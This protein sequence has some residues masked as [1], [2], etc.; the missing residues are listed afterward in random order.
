MVI[1][2]FNLKTQKSNTGYI[3]KININSYLLQTKHYNIIL[4]TK[5]KLNYYDQIS[6]NI[7]DLKTV[8]AFKNT[9]GFNQENYFISNNIKYQLNSNNLNITKSNSFKAQ[10]KTYIDSLNDQH[11][12]ILNYFIFGIRDYENIR[13]FVLESGLNYIGLGYLIEKIFRIFI[14]KKYSKLIK[15][16]ILSLYF[17][18]NSSFSLLRIIIYESLRYF[19]SNKFQAFGYSGLIILLLWPYKVYSVAFI[20]PFL[21]KVFELFNILNIKHKTCLILLSSFFFSK[22]NF[23][24]IFFFKFL[25]YIH[26]LMILCSFIFLY[27]S[28]VLIFLFGL[29]QNLLNIFSNKMFIVLGKINIIGIL[30]FMLFKTLFKKIKYI[31]NTVIITLVLLFNLSHIHSQVAIINVGDGDSILIKDRFNTANILIDTASPQ[32]YSKVRDF[33]YAKGVKTIDYLVITHYDLDHYGNLERLKKDFKVKN[34]MDKHTD[35]K[36][37]NMHFLSLNKPHKSKNDSSIVYL[38]NLN[39]LN[40]LFTGDITKIV[41]KSIINQYPLLK[42]DILKAG[43]H[44]SNTSSDANFIKEIDPMLALISCGN[45]YGFPKKETIKTFADNLIPYYVTK[46]RGDLQLYITAFGN[47][48]IDSKNNI[49][50][51]KK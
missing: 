18:L 49:V 47:F 28:K 14:N 45:N 1:L 46:D 44:G 27:N 34:V 37:N 32:Y 43:H 23:I 51:I 3:S 35:L 7:D 39:K 16:I 12:T 29:Y 6:F 17:Y 40:F 42:I 15:I 33:L 31:N 4:K 2:S 30:F 10:F 11:K 9:Y 26:A 38:L 36:I 5:H 13:D 41:E 22:V 20:F 25:A 8:K 21:I 50:S 48:L 19:I 24:K